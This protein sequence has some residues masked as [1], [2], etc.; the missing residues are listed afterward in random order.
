MSIVVGIVMFAVISLFGEIYLRSGS[1]SQVTLTQALG[2]L[3]WMRFTILIMPVQ[4]LI[5]AAVYY[6]GDEGISNIANAVQGLG[7]IIF[8]IVLSHFMGIRGIGLASFLFN[9]I[10]LLIF[11]LHFK[12]ESNSLRF[13]FYFSFS[14]LKDVSDTV[15]L[16]PVPICFSLFL[17]PCSISMLPRILVRST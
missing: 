2:Y 5:G 11:L 13:S 14:L 1:P 15:L 6:D 8:S 17:L 12:K 7:N 9:M 16:I 3:Y 4:M 10:S